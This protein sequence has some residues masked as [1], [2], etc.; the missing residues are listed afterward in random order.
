MI[1]IKMDEIAEEKDIQ[2]YIQIKN[3]PVKLL[4]ARED[5]ITIPAIKN[6]PFRNYSQWFRKKPTVGSWPISHGNN[7]KHY[8]YKG[9]FIHD[10]AEGFTFSGG[11]IMAES[12]GNT[13]F[14]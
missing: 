8:F 9:E 2:N 7:T 6:S 10:F 5:S 13:D 14:R 12:Y 1:I 11:E 3:K 4:V